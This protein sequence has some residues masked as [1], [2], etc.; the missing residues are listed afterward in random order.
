MWGVFKR[1]FL[2]TV[3]SVM[4]PNVHGYLAAR[5]SLVVQG[6][7]ENPITCIVDFI[8]YAGFIN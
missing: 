1:L 5:H 6:E 7:R 3:S 4:F 2:F 8:A